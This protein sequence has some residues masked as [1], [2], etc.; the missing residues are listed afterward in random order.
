MI[1]PMDELALRQSFAVETLQEILRG[2]WVGHERW[3]GFD[4]GE[5][6]CCAKVIWFSGASKV[7]GV[8]AALIYEMYPVH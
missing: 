7:I 5:E 4:E 3:C 1:L 6:C 8:H 2:W